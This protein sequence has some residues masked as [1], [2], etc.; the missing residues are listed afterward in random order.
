[1]VLV[2]NGIHVKDT[3]LILASQVRLFNA[4]LSIWPIRF[5]GL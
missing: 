3:L 1:V 2:E 4:C 5:E